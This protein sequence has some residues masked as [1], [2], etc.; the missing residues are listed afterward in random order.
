MHPDSQYWFAF[1]FNGKPYTF[2]R[3]YEGCCESPTIF[4]AAL[5]SCLDSLTL[6]PATVILTY[7]DD[8]MI[9]SPTAE[10]CEKFTVVLLKQI[11]V[12]GIKTSLSKLQF[13]QQQV[14]FLGHVIT[15]EGKS[16]SPKSTEAI[17]RLPK[18]QTKKTADALFRHVLL[19]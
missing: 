11:C 15:A 6:T 4:S 16:L 12:Y 2:P 10:Q 3:Q 1:T 19:L 9:C 7:V 8:L 14:T 18:S 13:L 5:K 17:Q